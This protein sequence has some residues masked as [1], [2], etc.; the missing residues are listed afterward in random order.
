MC[1]VRKN[2]CEVLVARRLTLI[3]EAECTVE[4]RVEGE[5]KDGRRSGKNQ[6]RQLEVHRRGSE[7]R[8]ESFS[9]FTRKT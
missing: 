7:W 9:L 6:A 5:L 3:E 4:S 2:N 1:E 8:G